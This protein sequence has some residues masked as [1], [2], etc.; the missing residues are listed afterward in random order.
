MLTS[1]SR[2]RF[3]SVART[4]LPCLTL[5]LVG[6][7]AEDDRPW[8]TALWL[9]PDQQAER[10]MAAGRFEEAA[11]LYTTPF[12]RGVAHF[13]AGEFEAAAAAFARMNS[14]DGFFNRGNAFAFL[15]KY[16]D[17]VKAYD[18]AL[19]L[20]PGWQSAEENREI[21]RL[22]GER[23]KQEGGEGTGGKLEA[24][25]YV[26]D[27]SKGDKPGETDTVEMDGGAPLSDEE[28]RA[29]WLRRVQTRPADFLRAKFAYQNAR[30]QREGTR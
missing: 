2:E 27:E 30:Q 11:K 21:A 9:T 23:L 26:F 7:G 24:D 4:L 10:F 8:W 20:R 1:R 13:R 19:G 22:R 3:R 5:L 16:E 14:A 12:R 28:L 17:A 29:L 15:G 25:D 6:C 18:Q